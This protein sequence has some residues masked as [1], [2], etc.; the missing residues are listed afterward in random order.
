MSEPLSTTDI[1]DVLSSIRRLVA[2]DMRPLQKTTAERTVVVAA[3]EV[4]APK[5]KLIL[6]P[7]LR[8]VSSDADAPVANRVS[9]VVANLG[10]KLSHADWD[11][12]VEEDTDLPSLDVAG[13]DPQSWAFAPD[14]DVI[15]D[16]A[17]GILTCRTFDADA[18]WEVTEEPGTPVDQPIEEADVEPTFVSVRRADL[19]EAF[20][21]W[22]QAEVFEAGGAA[23]KKPWEDEAA[24]EA[25]ADDLLARA[26]MTGTIEPDPEWADAAEADVLAEL[27]MQ[28]DQAAVIDDLG[29]FGPEDGFEAAGAEPDFDGR[30]VLYDEGLLRE[31]VREL[32]REELQGNMGERI[33]RNIRKL[34]RAE[35]A[36]ALATQD[37]T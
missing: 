3:P 14:E 34:V 12:E 13:D 28:S 16:N 10:S 9:S 11:A 7:A 21:G 22:A 33:T 6:T 37:L 2:E 15:A 18:D 24:T 20:P 1:E 19:V 27:A 31:I 32:L 36:R 29:V 23:D 35:I 17:S 5:N 26:P 8:V 30:E 25:S 4:P